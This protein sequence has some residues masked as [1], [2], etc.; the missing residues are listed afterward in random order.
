MDIGKAFSFVFDDEE[1]IKKVLIGAVLTLTGIGMIPVFGYAIE[2]ARRVARGDEKPL[3]EWDDFGAKIIEGLLAGLVM[4]VWALPLILIVSCVWIIPFLLA[5]VD[6]TGEMVAVVSSILSIC[7]GLISLIYGLILGLVLP[8][9]VTHY[10]VTGEIKAAFS[11]GE[12]LGMVRNNIGAYLMVL[13]IS[14]IAQ[15][16]GSLGFIL[17]CIGVY[18]TTFYAVLVTYHAYGQAYRIAAGNVDSS[19]ELAY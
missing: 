15:L 17:L 8:A 4:F 11:F 10:A 2:I 6:D 18:A 12:I 5:G 14:V 9:A 1:W 7:V 16:L 3:P 19:P 13:L